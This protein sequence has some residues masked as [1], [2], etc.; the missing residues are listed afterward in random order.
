MLLVQVGLAF[1]LCAL[2]L[3]VSYMVHKYGLWV[4]WQ[5]SVAR[6]NSYTSGIYHLW[7]VYRLRS[8]QADGASESEAD[9]L[10]RNLHAWF[11]RKTGEVATPEAKIQKYE[12]MVAARAD[13]AGQ[14][15]EHGRSP[16]PAGRRS[17]RLSQP[18]RKFDSADS[19]STTYY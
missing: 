13:R 1:A 7:A 11:W 18:A 6:K 8:A 2:V 4:S 19:T 17:G 10:S 14:G 15:Q 12:A 16:S 5:K 3:H 9:R